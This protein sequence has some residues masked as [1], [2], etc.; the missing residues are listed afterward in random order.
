MSNSSIWRIDRTLLGSTAPRQSG[1]GSIGKEEA[2]YVS[3]I[4]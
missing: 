1:T 4:S 3:E 2:L